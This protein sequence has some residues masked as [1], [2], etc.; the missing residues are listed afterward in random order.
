MLKVVVLGFLSLS[1][2][3]ISNSTLDY[4]DFVNPRGVEI[5]IIV[6]HDVEA[7]CTNFLMNM[8]CGA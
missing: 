1:R 8:T 2:E 3:P 7:T 6:Q 4:K 5:E